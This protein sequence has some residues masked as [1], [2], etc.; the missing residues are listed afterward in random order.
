[1]CSQRRSRQETIMT[2]TT[3]LQV[4]TELLILLWLAVTLRTHFSH[5][6][7]HSFLVGIPVWRHG[8]GLTVNTEVCVSMFSLCCSISVALLWIRQT[9]LVCFCFVFPE[10]TDPVTCCAFILVLTISL[11]TSFFPPLPLGCPPSQPPIRYFSPLKWSALDEGWKSLTYPE[12][13]AAI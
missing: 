10:L 13:I 2:G 6:D 5:S 8:F 12:G 3:A 4:G 1:M 7:T 9:V 11:I